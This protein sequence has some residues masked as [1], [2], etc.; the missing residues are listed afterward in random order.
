MGAITNIFRAFT[1][2]YLDLFP[3]L[4]DQHKKVIDAIVNCRSGNLGVAVYRC[5][6]CGK[7]HYIDRSCGNRHCPGCQYH[8]SRDWLENQLSRRLP[9]RHFML[10]FTMP[11]QIRPFCRSHQRIAYEALFKTA[12]ESI[13]KLAKDP[14]YIGCDLPGFTG[15]LH[16]W[17]RQ[18]QY[19]PHLHFIVPAGGLSKN[20]NKWLVS[21][22]NFYLPVR[23][24][25][26]IFKA[27]FKAEMEKN[28]ML[29]FIDPK[30]WQITWNVNCQ[31]VGD[32]EAALKYLAPYVF[33]VAISDNRIVDVLGRN[34]T[35]SYRK[36]GSNRSRNI[37]IDALEFIRRFLQHVLPSGFMKVRHFGFMNSACKVSFAWLRLLVLAALEKISFELADLLVKKP[38]MKRKKPF[39]RSCGAELLY[40]F[41]I[42]PGVPCRAPT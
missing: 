28:G 6:A 25:A 1:P 32:A 26:K 9:C 41:S 39:C 19:H 33:R 23:A 40:L 31:A 3:N 30:V 12:S 15:V 29:P 16:T 22:N 34:V 11:E 36:S 21:G 27:K 5:E 14:A 35:F 4:P 38:G 2:E 24:L 20:R 7:S 18:L 13:K 8:K 17:G 37:I 42:I 10:T